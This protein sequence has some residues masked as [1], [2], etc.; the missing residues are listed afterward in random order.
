M[1]SFEGLLPFVN[2]YIC[3]YHNRT[4]LYSL[5]LNM[6][7]DMYEST[8]TLHFADVAFPEH[9][10][11]GIILDISSNRLSKL[12][13]CVITRRQK[14]HP[15][16]K[17]KFA[18]KGIDASNLSNILNQKSAQSNIPP[19]FQNKKSPYISYSYTRSD[20]SKIFNY[21]RSMQQIDYKSLYQ[22]ILPCN[23]SSS[24][25]LYAP[26]GHVVTGGLNIVRNEKLRACTHRSE[27]QG[28][29]L[30]FMAPKL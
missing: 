14:N 10:R 18:N 21:K 6:L 17:N 15:F 4:R 26:C 5:P 16:L 7:H 2:L 20:A 8:F 24:K 11:Q 12:S 22:N 1:S 9:R 3:L 19:Y 25:F 29:C 13:G 30:I 28:T 23:C 27:I